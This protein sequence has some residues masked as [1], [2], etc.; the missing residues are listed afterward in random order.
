MVVMFFENIILIASPPSD[1]D[2][3]CYFSCHLVLDWVLLRLQSV[4]VMAPITGPGPFWLVCTLFS[5]TSWNNWLPEELKQQK[6][7]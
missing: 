4:L 3:S 2:I 7:F 1:L 6:R 5:L